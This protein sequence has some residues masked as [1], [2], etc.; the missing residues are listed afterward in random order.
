MKPS[1]GDARARAADVLVRAAR[2]DAFAA[3]LLDA[4]LDRAPALDARDRALCTELVYGVLRTQPALDEALGRHARDGAPQAPP[5]P[6]ARV[7][8]RQR[9]PSREPGERVQ[10]G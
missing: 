8:R 6:Q 5:A 10:A 9:P 7:R 4:A 3:P 2:D 1:H